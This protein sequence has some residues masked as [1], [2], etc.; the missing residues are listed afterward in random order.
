[1]TEKPKLITTFHLTKDRMKIAYELHNPTTRDLY[2][3]NRLY[4][5][6]PEWKMSPDVIYVHFM[7]EKRTVWVNKKLAEIPSGP[8]ITSPVAPYVTPVR[9][10]D[11][12]REEVVVPLPITEYRQYNGEI[13]AEHDLSP[14]ETYKEIY[15][16]LGYYWRPEGTEEEETE[17][18]GTPVIIPRPPR[19]SPMEFGI[20]DSERKQLDLNVKLRGGK[21]D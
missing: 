12:F 21:L 10:G 14:L 7:P 9:A 3:L 18:H 8:L 11:K 13:H 16:S 4:L 19:A 15:F 2:L 20:L 17:V 1:M 6:T 5:T